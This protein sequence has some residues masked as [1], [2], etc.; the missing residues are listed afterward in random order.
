VAGRKIELE[1]NGALMYKLSR[2]VVESIDRRFRQLR[3]R[4]T[5]QIAPKAKVIHVRR[6][7]DRSRD[8]RVRCVG[9]RQS[10]ARLTSAK[11]T[12]LGGE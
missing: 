4:D 5:R 12:G 3:R 2:K 10:L 9:Q 1:I 11:A 6:S 8:S 7:K